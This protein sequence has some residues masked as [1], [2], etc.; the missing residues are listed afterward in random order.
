MEPE[1][2][3]QELNLPVEIELYIEPDGT[4]TFADLAAE[5]L[6]IATS[7]HPDQPLSCDLPPQ[8]STDQEEN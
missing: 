1:D 7:L 5:A 3:K 6:P 2:K 4:V 8:E